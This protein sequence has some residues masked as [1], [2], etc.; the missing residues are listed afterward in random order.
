MEKHF[1]FGEAWD[2]TQNWKENSPQNEFYSLSFRFVV[3]TK[4]F[5]S[6]FS[7]NGVD[8]HLWHWGERMIR[9]AQNIRRLFVSLE[10]F[11]CF[12]LPP[13]HGSWC[14]NVRNES[15]CQA[16]QSRLCSRQG[17]RNS[18]NKWK[19][20]SNGPKTRTNLSEMIIIRFHH[21]TDTF[22][23]TLIPSILWLPLNQNHFESALSACFNAIFSVSVL[24]HSLILS[25]CLADCSFST[26]TCSQFGTTW[27]GPCLQ[28]KQTSCSIKP[29][30]WQQGKSMQRKK[31]GD[32]KLGGFEMVIVDILSSLLSFDEGTWI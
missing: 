8:E 16:F 31:R 21:Q 25:H 1:N 3:P 18:I 30:S 4:S 26:P 28:L 11:Q 15:L 32:P 19:W 27:V 22:L 2:F 14:S 29:N 10:I 9:M 23:L 17:N 7:Y 20:I 13:L 12:V 5:F 24:Y 6:S